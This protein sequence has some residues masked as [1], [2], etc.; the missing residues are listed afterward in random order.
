VVIGFAESFF[1]LEIVF[2]DAV[3]NDDDAARA[4]AMWMCVLFGGA[5][6][7][8]PARV[9]DAVSAVERAQANDLFEVAQFAFGAAD[10]EVVVFVDD[11]DTGGVVA[12]IF[13]LPQTID[14]ERHNLFIAYV[15]NNSTHAI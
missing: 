4:I 14:D 2:D 6:V 8:G 3:V 5:A 1:E 13:E 10:L 9:A 12:A 11:G 15:T 7:C